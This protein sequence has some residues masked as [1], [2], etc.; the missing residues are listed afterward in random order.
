MGWLAGHRRSRGHFAR[1]RRIRDRRSVALA[2]RGV[3]QGRHRAPV[4]RHLPPARSPG[5]GARRLLPAHARHR[6]G[7]RHLGHRAAASLAVRH[8]HR[9]RVHGGGRPP[10]GRPGPA[11]GPGRPR[12]AR[13]GCPGADRAAVR[14]AVR[15]RAVHDLLRADGQVVRDRDDV[16]RDRHLPAAAGLARR[17]LAVVAGVRG[18]RGADRPVQHLRAAAPGRAR[19]HAAAERRERPGR[20]PRPGRPPARGRAPG[21]PDP[22]A[23]AGRIGGRGARARPAARPGQPPAATDRLAHPAQSQRDGAA[24]H[25]PR[26]LPAADRPVRADHREAQAPDDSACGARSPP[27]ISCSRIFLRPRCSRDITVP[28]GVPIISA[29][30]R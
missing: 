8:G 29:I 7:R 2:G 28:T 24:A 26:G 10:G 3:H 20:G 27:A 30:S 18:G 5:R 4:R 9:D 1:G 19:D 13:P 23:L 25:Q 6:D 12:R 17:P 11:A 14:P 15:H 21:R 22:A 16:R